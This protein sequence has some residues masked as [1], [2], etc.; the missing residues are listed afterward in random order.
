MI[1]DLG[2][3][4][5]EWQLDY[6]GQFGELGADQEGRRHSGQSFYGL[7]DMIAIGGETLLGYRNRRASR[8]SRLTFDYDSVAAI[9]RF[10]DPV[11]NALGAGLWLQA[12]LDED[13]E[14]ARLEARGIIEKRTPLWWGQ[15]NVAYRRVNEE[16]KKGAYLPYAVQ[17]SHAVARD[18]WLGLEASGQLAKVSGFVREPLHKG[19]FFGPRIATEFRVSRR[20]RA[21][22]GLTYLRRVGGGGL[23][24]TVQLSGGIKF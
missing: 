8:N 19:Q 5:G 6:T 14:V 23:R 17:I 4:K 16:R 11:R 18:L 7:S 13:G 10:S 15:A 1:K 24:N 2:P 22:L 20:V 9:V 21:R 12:G 3:A